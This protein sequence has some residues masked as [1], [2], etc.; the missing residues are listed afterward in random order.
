MAWIKTDP[1]LGYLVSYIANGV[2]I[3]KRVKK[4]EDCILVAPE[5]SRVGWSFRGW[6]ADTVHSL[7][8]L[9]SKI[10]DGKGI[11]LYEVWSKTIQHGGSVSAG[12]AYW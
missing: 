6:R 2:D 9:P 8:V 11:I 4:G 12:P 3:K 7:S 1:A 5:V 10:C